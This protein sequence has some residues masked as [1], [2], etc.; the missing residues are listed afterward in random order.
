[1]RQPRHAFAAVFAIAVSLLAGCGGQP[2]PER[3]TTLDNP[4]ADD[5]RAAIEAINAETGEL[6]R[7]G[8]GASV[9][10]QYTA[11]AL[12]LPANAPTVSGTEAISQQ[13]QAAVDAGVKDLTLTATE[14]QSDGQ[15]AIEGGRFQAT[16]GSG[17]VVDDGKYL[18][19]WKKEASGWKRHRDM[20]NSDRP[21][22]PPPAPAD[23]PSVPA[24][25]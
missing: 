4:A 2:T 17:T 13:F 15:L 14:V 18:V 22:A 24:T 10:A 9:G 12:L 16:D 3:Q 8:K 1:M 19:V 20:F 6:I 5:V 21:P 23:T 7:A 11:D 25:E